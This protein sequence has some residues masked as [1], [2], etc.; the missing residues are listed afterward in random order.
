VTLDFAQLVGTVGPTAAVL[1]FMW[2]NRAP[3]AKEKKEDP[4]AALADKLNSIENRVIDV[5]ADLQIL[6]DRKPR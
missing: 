1:M 2:I 4:V 6:K 5:H 3:N